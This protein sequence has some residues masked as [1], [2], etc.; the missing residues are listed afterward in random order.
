M[1]SEP[2]SFLQLRDSEAVRA[3]ADNHHHHHHHGEGANAAVVASGRGNGGAASAS[4]GGTGGGASSGSGGGGEGAEGDETCE[5]LVAEF[6]EPGRPTRLQ[7][8]KEEGVTTV[9]LV[10]PP[11]S[12]SCTYVCISPIGAGLIVALPSD[13]LSPFARTAALLG[14]RSARRWVPI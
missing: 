8:G 11:L 4:A 9:C 10:S 6:L 2:S 14:L 3:V 7:H 5:L 13:L 1:E 12:P